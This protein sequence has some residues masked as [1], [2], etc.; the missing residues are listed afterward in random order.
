MRDRESR[1]S[2]L[3]RQIRV[4]PLFGLLFLL[5]HPVPA[6]HAHRCYIF[7]WVEG[8]TVYTESYFSGNRKVIDGVVT[9]FDSSGKELL[10]GR[11]NRKGEFSF[12][13]PGEIDMRI[14]LESSMGHRAEYLLKASEFSASPGNPKPV[15]RDKEPDGPVPAD[16]PQ[17][18][19]KIKAMMEEVLDVRLR[20][21]SRGLARLQEE[22]GPGLTEILGG[23]GYIFG[24]MGIVLYFKSR[25]R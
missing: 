4:I 8:D 10:H 7:A 23:I 12:K 2:I 17:D 1:N 24:L 18:M 13:I 25:K 15:P 21:I 11:T 20:P 3:R 6:A 19:E 5:L 22:R 9:V 16:N 14:V